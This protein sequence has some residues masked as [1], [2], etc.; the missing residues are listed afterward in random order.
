MDILNSFLYKII[1]DYTNIN[2]L[3]ELSKFNGNINISN[4][5]IKG[6]YFFKEKKYSFRILYDGSSIK[7]YILGNDKKQIFS[8][9]VYDT[10][11]VS[12]YLC[13][14]K[15]NEYSEKI[16][17][18]KTMYDKNKVFLFRKEILK[19]IVKIKKEQE[20]ENVDDLCF[21]D[22]VTIIKT[23]SKDLIKKHEIIYEKGKD[24]TVEYS[25]SSNFKEG[26][27]YSGNVDIDEYYLGF[28]YID[29]KEYN[30]HLEKI[31]YK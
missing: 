6:Y 2:K 5:E 18:K 26:I 12:R 11:Y 22:I 17:D 9:Y 20:I 14:S 8:S 7:G 1:N 19:E 3:I 25:M 4:K 16:I 29:E 30:K 31:F 28:N 24:K 21:K 27:F 15:L 10:N 23:G 13:T